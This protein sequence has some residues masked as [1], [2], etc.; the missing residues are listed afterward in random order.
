MNKSEWIKA[1]E[2]KRTDNNGIMKQQPIVKHP[3]HS[4]VLL[5]WALCTWTASITV[6][7]AI[8]KPLHFVSCHWLQ[9]LHLTIPDFLEDSHRLQRSV[10][11][12][13]ASFLLV[14]LPVVKKKMRCEKVSK[15]ERHMWHNH[16]CT[17]SFNEM[18]TFVYKVQTNFYIR[19]SKYGI[20]VFMV[21][22][23]Y[24]WSILLVS[25][26]DQTYES[27]VEEIEGAVGSQV[28]SGQF[29]RSEVLFNQLIPD[30][31][32]LILHFLAV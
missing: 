17:S 7:I 19:N 20:R 2:K 10:H 13:N 4:R 21:Q 12:W 24:F 9:V 27:Y 30:V 5:F 6:V 23:F 29:K 22:N 1:V 32:L 28:K 8:R 25:L 3:I 26:Y 16:N 18:Y 31:V 14:P 15:K 11:L